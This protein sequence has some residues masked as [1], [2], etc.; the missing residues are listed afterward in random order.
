MTNICQQMSQQLQ[1]VFISDVVF[2]NVK[3]LKSSEIFHVTFFED[4]EYTAH[5]VSYSERCY[6]KH[7]LLQHCCYFKL[8]FK[9]FALFRTP[10]KQ[11]PAKISQKRSF[12]T[13]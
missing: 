10:N 9:T 4:P 1:T 6:V 12:L 7:Y 3:H 2:T 5:T 13:V 8:M 11:V